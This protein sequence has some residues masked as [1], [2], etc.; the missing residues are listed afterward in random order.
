METKS[1]HGSHGLQ[2]AT[3]LWLKMSASVASRYSIGLIQ[4]FD[5]GGLASLARA[6]MPDPS[7]YSAALPF[8]R[9]YACYTLL[10]KLEVSSDEVRLRKE[11]FDAFVASET[12]NRISNDRI[13]RGFTELNVEG[14]LSSARRK[15]Q[16]ILGDFDYSE[17]FLSCGWGPGSTTTLNRVAATLD[18]KISELPLS[19]TPKAAYWL[20]ALI[21]SSPAWCRARGLYVDGPCTLMVSEFNLTTESRLDS[22]AKDVTKRRTIDPQPTG[23]SFLQKGFGKMI[24]RRLKADGIDLNDQ[25][26]NRFLASVAHVFGLAT[27]DLK[28]ASNSLV[29]RLV[30]TL[31]PT[32]WFEIARKFRVTHTMIEDTRHELQ[33]FSAM[34]NGYTFELESLIFYALCWA[35]VRDEAGD[36]QTPISVYGDDIIIASKHFQRLHETFPQ[37]GLEVN[38]TKSFTKGPFYESCGGHYFNGIEVTPIYQK[39]ILADSP[40]LIRCANRL[41]RWAHRMGRG[42][43]LD[44]AALEPYLFITEELMFLHDLSESHRSSV[45]ERYGRKFRY[46]PIPTQPFGVEGD[47]GVIDP[48]ITVNVEKPVMVFG[49]TYTSKSRQAKEDALLAEVLRDKGLEDLYHSNTNLSRRPYGLGAY[50][51]L[52][53]SLTSWVPDRGVPSLGMVPLRGIGRYTWSGGMAWS[54]PCQPLEWL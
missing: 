12:K 21:G 31:L 18:N 3:K 4:E 7:E 26:R 5:R 44:D 28:D 47:K 45:C 36:L 27:V 37:L 15:I 9:D 1:V 19:V 25:S 16:Q 32:T 24:R 29:Y 14:I 51:A 20:A 52:E 38:D 40:D 8:G 43:F 33:L 39:E 34:G 2:R 30:E 6:S 46:R 22:V 54:K 11:A 23:N 48:E 42:R 41:Y 50:R 53:K 17:F 13:N 49:Y 10:R 35:I